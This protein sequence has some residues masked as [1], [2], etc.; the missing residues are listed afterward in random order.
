[1]ILMLGFLAA[2]EALA[3]SSREFRSHGNEALVEGLFDAASRLQR[4]AGF[5]EPRFR[6]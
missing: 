5:E 4:D 1:V 2:S 3:A 6:T